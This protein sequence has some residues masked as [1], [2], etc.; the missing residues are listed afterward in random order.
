MNE[1]QADSQYP[2][3]GWLRTVVNGL[4]S[5]FT[6]SAVPIGSA[7]YRAVPFFGGPDL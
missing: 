5:I 6:R 3:A 4:A 2:F 7:S 1:S